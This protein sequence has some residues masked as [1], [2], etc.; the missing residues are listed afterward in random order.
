MKAAKAASTTTALPKASRTLTVL[1]VLALALAAAR[2]VLPWAI[3]EDVAAHAVVDAA[4]RVAAVADAV[5]DAIA[6]HA[7]NTLFDIKARLQ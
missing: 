5:G 6:A 7:G 1:K 2:G 4:A 3:V